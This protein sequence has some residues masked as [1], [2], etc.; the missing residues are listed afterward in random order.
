MKKTLAEQICKN[1]R[2]IE[3]KIKIRKIRKKTLA[4]DQK[5]NT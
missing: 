5:D 1:V 3:N 4:N 2:K